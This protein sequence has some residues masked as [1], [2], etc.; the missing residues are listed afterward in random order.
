ML[1]CLQDSDSRCLY[2]D[3]SCRI[4]AS[5]LIT[6]ER[7]ECLV[8]FVMCVTIWYVFEDQNVCFPSRPGKNHW[9]LLGKYQDLLGLKMVC[10]RWQ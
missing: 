1:L 7:G 3:Q 6:S 10:W 5:L 4:S 9:F 8:R 2:W